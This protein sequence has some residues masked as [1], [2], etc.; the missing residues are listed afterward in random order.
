MKEKYSSDRDV[1][2]SADQQAQLDSLL[3]R[4]IQC[5]LCLPTCATYL[6]T[7]SEVQSP[8]GRLLLLGE[9]LALKDRAAVVKGDQTTSFTYQWDLQSIWEAFDLCLGCRACQ[10][11]CPSGVSFALLENGKQLAAVRLKRD[12]QWLTG[13]LGSRGRM[14]HLRRLAAGARSLLRATMGGD[15]RVRL[16][17]AP[18]WVWRWV[19]RLGTL[20]SE[21]DGNRELLD[22]LDGLVARAVLP[23]SA[24]DPDGMEQQSVVTAPTAVTPVKMQTS[25]GSA[26]PP[27]TL[28]TVAFFRGCVNDTLL[29][30]A[31]TRLRA[32]LVAAGCRILEP[33]GTR[34]CGALDR[35]TGR[36][37]RADKLREANL[38]SLSASVKTWDVL[39][40]EAAGCGLEL[41][42]YPDEIA[43]RVQDAIA[44]LATLQ[45]PPARPVPL[46]VAVHDPCH[47]RHGQSIVDEPRQLLHRIPSLTVVEP[48]EPEVCCGSGGA[49]SLVHTELSA[50]MGRR[51]A[52]QLAATGADLV[53]TTNPGCLGQI[54]D[55][56]SLVAPDL[57]ILSLSDL[58]WYA[59][60]GISWA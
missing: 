24:E 58:L 40:V 59:H 31:A 13:L 3:R 30:G 45:L 34:C 27:V 44:L 55:S 20:P 49:F 50:Q 10:T 5:G 29:P 47:A 6:A 17:K 41:K 23:K 33:G 7:G 28:P 18:R 56:L 57:P 36:Q 54:A 43:S 32:L 53:V 12:R 35:H 60:L 22:L 51:K 39:V 15:W 48:D 46:R 16:E 37:I 2:L 8:R 11:S 38:S 26:A 14:R 19:R 25:T 9:L 21:P 52:R 1:A 42:S 4:C